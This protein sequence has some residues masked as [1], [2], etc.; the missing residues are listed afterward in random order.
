[1]RVVVSPSHSPQPSSSSASEVSLLWWRP[2]T[3]G[4]PRRWRHDGRTRLVTEPGA[5]LELSIVLRGLPDDVAHSRMAGVIPRRLET[6]PRRRR[7]LFTRGD[8]PLK[9]LAPAPLCVP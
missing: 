5:R 3:A 8:G 1:M 2:G 4:P 6:P 9:V 7:R